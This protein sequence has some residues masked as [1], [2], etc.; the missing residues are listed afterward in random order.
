[1]KKILI[2]NGHPNTNSF[3]YVLSEAYKKGATTQGC[4]MKQLDIAKL[5][6]DVFNLKTFDTFK[7]PDDLIKA[8]NDI[9]WADHL[10][11]FHPIWWGTM[12]AIVKSFFEQT[13]LMGF[14]AK[15][16]ANGKITKLLKNKTASFVLTMDTPVWIYK[17]L[18]K[19]PVFKTHKANLNF[20]GI[21][22]L[23]RIYL[24]PII[25]SDDKKRKYWIKKVENLGKQL[26]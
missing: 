17:Y 11:W 3:N 8:Q 14:A 18:L 10:V 15:Y 23:K 21:S 12:P 24:G 13:F 1:M 22:P 25:K 20:C 9:K 2:I 19:D 6:F 7:I 5:K 26:T 16:E 4:E